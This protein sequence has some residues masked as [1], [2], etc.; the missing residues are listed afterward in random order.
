MFQSLPDW[1]PVL[2]G[3]LHD[4]FLDLLFDQPRGQ[5]AQIGRCRAD[6]LVYE[7]KVAVDFDIGHDDRQHL[8][9][10]SIPA[11][12]YG[13]GLSFE[14]GERASSYHSGSR[15]IAVL[16]DRHD[17]QLFGQS[18]TPR[19]IQLLNLDRPTGWFDLAA[20]VYH[21]DL[22]LDFHASGGR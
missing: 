17:A 7:V 13:I 19:V 20:P 8:L 15:A 12:R 22:P 18:R 9:W 16:S 21:S 10:A 1:P 5:S 6:L 4:D 14:S 11:I 3:R 2:R